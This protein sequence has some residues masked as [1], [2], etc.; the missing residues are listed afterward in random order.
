MKILITTI[1]SLV[2]ALPALA[3]TDW[4]LDLEA[5]MVN[6]E[7]NDVAIPSDTGTRFS[8]TSDLKTDDDV[9]FRVGLGLRLG[10]RNSLTAV[11][12]PLMLYSQGNVDDDINYNG[13]LFE[14]GTDLEADYKFNTYRLRWTYD[15][16][17]SE[18]FVLGLGLT[19][20]VRDAAITVRDAERSTT[21]DN[22]GFVPLLNLLIDWRW[23]QKIGLLVQADAAAAPGGQ[24][25]AE[26][27]L[28]ALTVRPF[29]KGQFRVG[30]RFLEGGA[31]VDEV[32]NFA[33]ISYYVFGWSQRF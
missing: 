8:L 22:L 14:A 30:Y 6:A 19:G 1:I 27:V 9:A 33:W 31:D 15:L 23:T 17:R 24:G 25:R 3:D 28:L 4:L 13:V 29:G 11:W 26:D 5:A 10:E 12:A 21:Y 2:C 32:Y 20:L 7:S 16:V 18:R